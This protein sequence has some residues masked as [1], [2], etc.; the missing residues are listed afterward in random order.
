MAQATLNRVLKDIDALELSELG[1][2]ERAVKERRESAGYS[3]EEWKAIQALIASG[4]IT[5]IKPRSKQCLTDFAP[6]PIQGKPL[7]ETVV[8]ERR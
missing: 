5:E 2:V 8:E 7:S 3:T 4:L 6:I 1:S